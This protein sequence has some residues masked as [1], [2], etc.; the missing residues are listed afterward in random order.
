MHSN[1]YRYLSVEKWDLFFL[2]VGIASLGVLICW[3]ITEHVGE[4]QYRYMIRIS[5]RCAWPI[6][7]LAFVASSVRQLWPGAVSNWLLRNRKYVGLAFSAV[8][9]WQVYFIVLL[10]AIAEE[11]FPPGIGQWFLYSDL[12]GYTLLLAMSVTSFDR[13]KAKVKPR[14]WRNLHKTGIYYIWFIYFYTYAIGV[15]YPRETGT[16]V[17]SLF[18]LS[19]LAGGL[20]RFSAFLAKKRKLAPGMA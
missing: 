13:I 2:I 11:V 18:F 3:A 5:V 7:L 8:M 17:Y 12:L 19:A 15:V 9:L 14:A 1:T 10:Y 16:L 6:L 4:Q 20:L